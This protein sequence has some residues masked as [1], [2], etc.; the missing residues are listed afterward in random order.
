MADAEAFAGPAGSGGA[1]ISP[2]GQHY[3]INDPPRI[4][5][6]GRPRATQA[7]P[8]SRAARASCSSSRLRW[9]RHRASIS[10]ECRSNASI[11]LMTA[12]AGRPAKRRTPA[13]RGSLRPVSRQHGR[14]R[15]RRS[16]VAA[17]GHPGDPSGDARHAHRPAGV[18]SDA[19]RLLAARGSRI[20]A[21]SLEGTF[22]SPLGPLAMCGRC[23]RSCTTGQMRSAA[24]CF[25][26][27]ALIT[28]RVVS[29]SSAF[30]IVEARPV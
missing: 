3:A 13:D 20:G 18:H 11:R 12:W 30:S 5:S 15:W 6:V 22:S 27:P 1:L 8:S 10:A 26:R 19:A 21:T 9:F 17:G 16:G 4:G 14:G 24:P 28:P 7:R 29:T 25:P 2:A 23:A